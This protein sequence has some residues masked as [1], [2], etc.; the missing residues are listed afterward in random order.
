MC[1][2]SELTE[3]EAKAVR[4]GLSKSDADWQRAA[5]DG[6]SGNISSLAYS[7]TGVYIEMTLTSM[8][9]NLVLLANRLD[10]ACQI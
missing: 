3:A 5:K 6:G 10:R 1:L 7:A 2:L 8:D 4:H 9:R